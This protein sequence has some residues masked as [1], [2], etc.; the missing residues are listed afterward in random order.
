MMHF[1]DMFEIRITGQT[2]DKEGDVP[3]K[4]REKNLLIPE[5]ERDR[6]TE[7][8]SQRQRHRKREIDIER[9]REGG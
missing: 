9:D 8:Q 7:S 3:S 6:E 2:L 4:Y 1:S 5:R